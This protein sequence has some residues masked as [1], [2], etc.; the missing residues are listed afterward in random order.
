MS[1]RKFLVTGGTDDLWAFNIATSFACN[2]IDRR[3]DTLY[4][5][6]MGEDADVP[7]KAAEVHGVTLEEI[8]SVG[9]EEIYEMIHQGKLP[10]WAAQ[11]EAALSEKKEPV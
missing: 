3:W 1:V 6:C 4:Y 7:I 9:D 10:G 8:K 11:C 2:F 5:T